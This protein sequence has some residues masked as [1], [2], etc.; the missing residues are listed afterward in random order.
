MAEIAHAVLGKIDI[1]FCPNQAE[2]EI[3]SCFQMLSITNMEKNLISDQNYKI[4]L[5][6]PYLAQFH[7][8]KS[9]HINFFCLPE[10]NGKKWCNL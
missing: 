10:K 3:L 9:L 5:S 4:L 8:K 2:N 7:K 6:N 1:F